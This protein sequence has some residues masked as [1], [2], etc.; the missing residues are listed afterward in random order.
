MRSNRS[1]YSSS[2]AGSSRALDQK[3]RPKKSKR[4]WN[5]RMLL[6]FFVVLPVLGLLAIF[7]QPFRWLFMLL[8][9]LALAMMWLI[10][11]FLFP[12]RMILTAGYGLMLVFTLVTALSA[13]DRKNT[14]R[15]QNFMATPTVAAAVSTPTFNYSAMG[16]SVPEGYFDA[17]TDLASVQGVGVAG[18]ADGEES[19]MTDSTDLSMLATVE[20]SDAEIALENFM[21]KWQKG[22]IA[23]MV[24]Y[25]P[26]SWRNSQ[27]ETSK[28][29]AQ[30]QL[31]WKFAQK[32]LLDWRQIS[33]PTGTAD[34]TA[35]T[36]TVQADVN[37][38][39]ETR[40]Y[41]YDA[42]ALMED[43]AWY[44][45][46]DSLSSGVLVPSATATPDP[47]A[48]PTPAPT[49]TPEPTTNPKTKLYYNKDGGSYYHAD[50]ECSS[51][52]KKFLPLASF[53]FGDLDESPYNKLKPCEE[54]GAPVQ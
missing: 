27:Q 54:C 45:D 30:Q 28:Q 41:E 43:G 24:A 38:G 51:V 16:T 53:T 17:Q 18:Q 40:T 44:V 13:S 19:A 48:T 21:E 31:F 23:D 26:P 2:P 14:I 20:K 5:Q 7:L 15:Q 37:Y 9:V 34:S 6:I 42:I 35:R 12:G 33:S 47:N 49:D 11:A 22:I 25:T 29:P 4:E 8:T 52:N 3:P 46:P 39:G 10:R 36:I 32:P 1:G 50:K